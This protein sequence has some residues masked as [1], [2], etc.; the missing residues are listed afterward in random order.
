MFYYGVPFIVLL[1][2]IYIILLV[3]LMDFVL[4]FNDNQ[5]LV[6]LFSDFNMIRMLAITCNLFLNE[7]RNVLYCK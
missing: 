7:R 1:E 4:S 3:L 6:F 5:K 2:I